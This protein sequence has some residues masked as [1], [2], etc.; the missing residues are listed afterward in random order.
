MEKLI[1]YCGLNCA[2]CDAYTATQNNDQAL[3]EK[4]AEKWTKMYN[5]NFSPEM[6][7]C[8]SC[9]GSG[10]KVGHCLQCEVRKCSS[11]KDI[12]NCGACGDFKDCKIINDF[13]SHVPDKN[14][15]LENLGQR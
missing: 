12:V 5:F 10:V 15:L 7:N 2:E 4:T 11:G 1:A 8:T 14:Q 3:R 9:Q 6:I 13:L